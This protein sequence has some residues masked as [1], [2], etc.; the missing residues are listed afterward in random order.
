MISYRKKY[1]QI[2]IWQAFSILLG[3]ASLFV[4]VPYLSSDKTLYG[5]YS[6]CTSLTIFFSY[7]DLGVLSAG[8]KYAAEY[9]IKGEHKDEM[10]VIGFT[11]F[12]MISV[13]SILALVIIVFAVFPKILIPELT[14]GSKSFHIAR[15]L[16][17][18][19]A[20]AC[21]IIIGQ[22]ILG[23]VFTIRVEDYKFQ[24]MQI[25]GNLMRILSVLYFFHNGHYQVV[26]YYIFYQF[27]NLVI[28]VVGLIYA[29]RYGYNLKDFFSSFRFD[30]EIFDK[31]KKLS[32]TS[33]LMIVSMILYYELD[34]IVISHYIGIEAVAVYGAALSVLTFVRTFNSLV[35]SPYSSRYN[36]FIGVR[37]FKGVTEFV[38]KIILMFTP[39]LMI[40][41]LCLAFCAKSFVVSWIG[42]S[43]LQSATLVSF[44]VLSFIPNCVSN[45][46]SSFF[47]STE[48]NQLLVKYNLI[49]PIIYW[50][51]VFL[52]INS[53]GLM[54]FALFKFIAPAITAIA[55]W[56][57]AKKSFS[58][59]GY[60]FLSGVQEI[61]TIL[62]SCIAVF[63][64][65]YLLYPIMTERH[66]KMALLCNIAIMGL[67]VV[68]SLI[69]VV[70]FNKYLRMEACR[71]L[72]IIRK[73]S[74]N[75]KL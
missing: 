70:P 73:K 6:V 58:Y 2:Y 37:D 34:Q 74:F 53:Y 23:L 50:A 3:F 52:C 72:S 59:L 61:K 64:V 28:V 20:I 66:D 32:G 46:I 22:R 21:P 19:L 65:S 48:R 54:S 36:H 62:I 12:V 8:V 7:A 31:V 11:A 49:Q 1:I 17:L 13:F 18:T 69:I 57:M 60:S 29:K 68:V 30:K 27:V 24:R 16:L 35:Y 38:N 75:I 47:I 9:Y 42:E 25:A 5:I 14:E 56:F 10:R 55:Y 43:Y 51:G 67:C 33:L 26:E 71:C 41:I 44:L 39:I 15:C 45:P 63:G 4:V 40:P